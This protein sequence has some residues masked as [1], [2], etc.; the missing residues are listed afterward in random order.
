MLLPAPR[1]P[2]APGTIATTSLVMRRLGSI[3]STRLL[4]NPVGAMAFLIRALFVAPLPKRSFAFGQLSYRFPLRDGGRAVGVT[5]GADALPLAGIAARLPISR[6]AAFRL[7]RALAPSLLLATCYLPGRFSANTLCVADEGDQR[8]I[9]IERVQTEATRDTLLA[10]GRRL[11][12]EIR[13]LGAFAVPGSLTIAQPGADAHYAGTLPMGGNGPAACAST[14]ELK[15]CPGLYIADGAPLPDLP[16]ET[17]HSDHHGKRRPHRTAS[18]VQ[19]Q[20]DDS[21]RIGSIPLA[22]RFSGG[23]AESAD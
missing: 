11:A 9:I 12:R 10:V 22:G 21:P 20:T 3:S 5:Y 17:L 13:R 7:T 15:G 18:S 6:P 1:I 16:G 4:T 8:H 23:C 14:G 2:L 19:K